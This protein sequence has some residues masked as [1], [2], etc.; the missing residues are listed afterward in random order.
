MLWVDIDKGS[1]MIAVTFELKNGWTE[2]FRISGNYVD[3]DVL[4]NLREKGESKSLSQRTIQ[5]SD[6][7]SDLGSIGMIP[8][9]DPLVIQNG[10]FGGLGAENP[11]Y[12]C[13]WI[14]KPN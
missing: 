9:H 6:V 7:V 1:I 2:N 8:L 13:C 5:Y 14:S 10:E 12:L 3:N 11:E 4:R